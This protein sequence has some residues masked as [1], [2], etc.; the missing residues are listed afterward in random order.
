MTAFRWA[1]PSIADFTLLSPYELYVL[2]KAYGTTNMIVW[3]KGGGATAVDVTVTIDSAR[4]QRKLLEVMPEEKGIVVLSAADSVILTGVVS[5]ALKARYAEQVANAY[6]RDV[7]K[8]LVMPALTGGNK[9]AATGTTVAMS[10]G[11]SGNLSADAVA[12]ARV[13]N[14]LQI[15]EAQQV[16]L[17]VK[18]AEVSKTLLDKLGADYQF[19][20]GNWGFVVGA[21]A[22]LGTKAIT[23]FANRFLIDAKANDGLVKIL[24]E[25]NIVAISGQEASFLAGGKIYIPVGRANN[26]TGGAT[27]TLE[28]KEYGVGLKFTPTVLDGGRINL[29]VAPEVS[30]L[31]QTGS[32]FTTVDNQVSILPTITTRRVQT[33][34]QLMDGQSFAIAGLLKNNVTQAMKRLPG[35]GEV[36]VIGALARSAEFQADRSELMFVITPRLVKPLDQAYI[37]P[38]DG[39]VPPN[40][41][42]FLLGGKLEGSG[43]PAIPVDQRLAP[44]PQP[45][46][47]EVK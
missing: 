46:G 28:E 3:R 15:A 7:N 16:M 10:S 36:P 24:A 38:T 9:N 8:S 47:L 44:V 37:L 19:K 6:V 43:T 17:E 5:S 18:I 39:F 42:E 21:N 41:A 27:V 40:R 14:L 31:S 33:T 22:I 35:I 11:A 32:P 4:M 25:P 29:K 30:E 13:V 12:G 45:G 2:G 23:D 26:V 34:V 1:I 20:S